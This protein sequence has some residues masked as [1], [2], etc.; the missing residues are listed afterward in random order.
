MLALAD[1][2]RLDLPATCYQGQHQTL[3]TV[4][5]FRHYHGS[6][7]PD[8]KGIGFL[9]RFRFRFRSGSRAI[10]SGHHFLDLALSAL[11]LPIGFHPRPLAVAVAPI[12]RT[13]H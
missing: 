8:S 4:L 2:I 1:S 13:G 7:P 5:R 3:Q 12:D 6:M 9:D 11:S 10:A